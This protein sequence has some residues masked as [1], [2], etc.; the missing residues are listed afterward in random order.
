MMTNTAYGCFASESFKVNVDKFNAYLKT[1]EPATEEITPTRVRYTVT[2]KLGSA[3]WIES[4]SI[5]G[6]SWIGAEECEAPLHILTTEDP[7]EDP[8]D[9]NF[10]EFAKCVYGS[11][12]VRYIQN[13]ELKF[14]DAG[15]VTIHNDGTSTCVTWSA[16][17]DEDN[18]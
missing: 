16:D 7:I 4:D 8:T 2:D 17:W 3:I 13:E 18:R 15:E 1:L 5:T 10:R 6:D 11:V 12:R 9:F 14:I